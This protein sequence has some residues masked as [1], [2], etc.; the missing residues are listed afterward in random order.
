MANGDFSVTYFLPPFQLIDGNVG[1]VKAIS[2]AF[3]PGDM[4]RLTRK[5]VSDVGAL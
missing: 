4:L 3:P 1:Q 2:H 5:V